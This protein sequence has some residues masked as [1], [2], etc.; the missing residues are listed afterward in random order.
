[1]MV[2]VWLL[3]WWSLDSRVLYKDL[4]LLQL[5]WRKILICLLLLGSVAWVMFR[6]IVMR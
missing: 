1:M 5:M 3:L 4:L 2:D 6:R